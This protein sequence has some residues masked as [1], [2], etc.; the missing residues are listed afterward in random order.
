MDE[1]ETFWE[2]KDGETLV[3]TVDPAD[4]KTAYE[5][6]REVNASHPGQQMAIG[7][8][9]LFPAG[10]DC[11]AIGRR[12]VLLWLL[13]MVN[14][15]YTEVQPEENPFSPLGPYIHGTELDEAMFSVM[16]K[17]RLESLEN[18]RKGWPCDIEGFMR[19]VEQEAA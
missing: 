5:Y 11:H 1:S 12:C 4:L 2:P 13:A 17:T 8:E 9:H 7:F 16:A 3:P 19:Q 10:K 15:R 18:P 6:A 14:Q